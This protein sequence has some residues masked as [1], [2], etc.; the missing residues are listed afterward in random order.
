MISFYDFF[1]RAPVNAEAAKM[2]SFNNNI[3]K[4]IDDTEIKFLIKIYF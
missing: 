2:F 3:E 4:N 1:V